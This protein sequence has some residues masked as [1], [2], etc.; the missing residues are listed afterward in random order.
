MEIDF[1]ERLLDAAGPSGFE[2]RPAR[3][4]RDLLAGMK[5]TDRAVALSRAGIPV[6]VLRGDQD[7]YIT[8]AET[9]SLS[10]M[11]RASKRR[12]YA[13]VGHSPHWEQPA[14][15]VR[16][17]LAFVAETRPSTR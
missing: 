8:A 15:F 1:L 5:A 2:V 13:N 17:V 9:D 6:L 14:E 4:W 12:T 7:T 16:D 10:A 11:V 3:V